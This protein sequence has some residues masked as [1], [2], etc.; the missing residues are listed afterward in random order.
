MWHYKALY[1]DKRCFAITIYYMLVICL[2]LEI[3]LHMHY[4]AYLNKLLVNRTAFYTHSININ[5]AFI[6][7]TL[8]E[9]V[10][11]LG[12]SNLPTVSKPR[13]G[14]RCRNAFADR[15][16]A[17]SSTAAEMGR[18]PSKDSGDQTSEPGD[19]RSWSPPRSTTAGRATAAMAPPLLDHRP[20]GLC[21]AHIQTH[22][23]AVAQG[24]SFFDET[25]S[26]R[27]PTVG[28]ESRGGVFTYSHG[29]F[30]CSSS[31]PD[32]PHMWLLS[33]DC[34]LMME[35]LQTWVDPSL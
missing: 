21:Q 19:T 20:A 8:T 7:G 6:T 28:Q 35:L 22:S 14:I 11:K 16:S 1:F 15:F 5:T 27:A 34:L 24:L 33:L 25:T 2:L 10:T 12:K 26:L 9:C 30:W 32:I 3:I 23:R 17:V 18:S 4:L 31:L 13:R 29:Y